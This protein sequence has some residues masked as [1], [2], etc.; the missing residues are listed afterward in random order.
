V[1]SIAPHLRARLRVLLSYGKSQRLLCGRGWCEVRR[2]CRCRGGRR[3]CGAMMRMRVVVR[4]RVRLEARGVVLRRHRPGTARL[5]G[6]AA[7]MSVIAV[8]HVHSIVVWRR[9]LRRKG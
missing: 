5:V 4:L 1:A 7:A 6:G 3:T 8:V 2:E 9:H